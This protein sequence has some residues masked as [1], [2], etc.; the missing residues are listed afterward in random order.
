MGYGQ[1]PMPPPGFGGRKWFPSMPNGPVL[2]GHVTAARPPFPPGQ[3]FPPM[4]PPGGPPFPPGG[5]PPP[6]MNGPGF[7]G[8]SLLFLSTSR[9]PTIR[10]RISGAPPFPPNGGPPGGV[11]IPPF[12]PGQNSNFGLPP[13][14]SA[15]P[16][17][18]NPGQPVAPTIH[19]DRLRMLNTGKP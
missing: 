6:G 13:G 16:P 3:G 4:M 12:P 9:K 1:Q 17:N 15:S 18:P 7:G 19:P 14:A 5:M 2:K 11:A 8:M 10:I